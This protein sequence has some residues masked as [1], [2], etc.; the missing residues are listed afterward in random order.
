MI[1][2]P[3]DMSLIVQLIADARETMRRRRAE[4][5]AASSAATTQA[6]VPE[7]AATGAMS[8]PQ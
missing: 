2:H 7:A 1:Q 6:T 3:P 5:E 8:P 4:D